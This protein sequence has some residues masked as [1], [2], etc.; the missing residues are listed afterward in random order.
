MDSERRD[1]SHVSAEGEEEGNTPQPSG[2]ALDHSQRLQ[3]EA[4]VSNH[5]FTRQQHAQLGEQHE[6]GTK[7]LSN[8]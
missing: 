3:G 5:F 2:R 7:A 1:S 6:K 8:I 4:K